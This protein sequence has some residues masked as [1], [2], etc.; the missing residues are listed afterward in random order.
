MLFNTHTK[1]KKIVCVTSFG[2]NVKTPTDVAAG[3]VES[4]VLVRPLIFST[5]GMSGS[6]APCCHLSLE[7]LSRANPGMPSWAPW[8]T[9][10]CS[11]QRPTT[12]RQR[13][14]FS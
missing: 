9:A 8:L 14:F 4:S 10:F 13:L 1:K 5:P 12:V 2:N 6:D 7:G 11:Q 3:L